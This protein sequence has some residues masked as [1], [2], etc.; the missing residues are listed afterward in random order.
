MATKE[1]FK[2]DLPLFVE[3][4]LVAIKQ[5]DEESAKKL[6]NAVGVIDPQSSMK[7]LGFGLIAIHKMD[8]ASGIKMFNE[9]LAAE[10]EN[11]RAMA[12][13]GFAH[14]LSTLKKETSRD[15]KAEA[16]RKGVEIAQKVLASTD[17]PSTCQLAQSM[18]DWE[19]ELQ[20]KAEAQ[21]GPVK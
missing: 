17:N 10:P 9:I 3:A 18:L 6:F 19:Q 15:E 4:G 5:G 2:K 16:L 21:K 12:F 1:E 7:K 8:I 20:K 14:L 11:Y 13:L